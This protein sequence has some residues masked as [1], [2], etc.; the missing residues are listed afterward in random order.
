MVTSGPGSLDAYGAALARHVDAPALHTRIGQ[1]SAERFGIP[2]LG[3][4]ALRALGADVR[5]VARLR[6]QPPALLHFASHHL[7]RY[8]PL[9]GKP[10]VGTVHDLIRWFDLAGAIPALIHEPNL[11]DRAMI[12]ADVAGFR[13]AAALVAVSAATRRDIVEHLGIAPERVHVVYEG[14]DHGRFRPM[15]PARRERPYV[16]FVGSEHP[17]KNLPV[18]LEAFARLKREPALAELTLLKVGASGSREAPFH[19][20][21]RAAIR[22]LGLERDVEFAGHVPDDALPALYA[23][24]ACLAFPSRHEGFGLPPLEAMAC[25]CPVVASTAGAIPE[26]TAGAALTVAPDDVDALADALRAVLTD[27]DLRKD[28]VG[29]GYEVAGRYT[30][31]R[32]ARALE[33]VYEEVLRGEAASAPLR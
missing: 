32:A 33:A 12:R 18:L 7:A 2:A 1:D 14:I 22:A 27:D 26:V 15:P 28:L 30:W 19:A 17:R 24:A 25:G 9:A 20:P 4:A 6:G 29:R 13:R 16:L 10:Y 31:A 11:R 3:T 8:G 5:F 21:V 23:G